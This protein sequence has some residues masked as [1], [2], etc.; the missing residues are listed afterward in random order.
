[1]IYHSYATI[2]GIRPNGLGF[3]EVVLQPALGSLT[4]VQ[5]TLPHPR[6]EIAVDFT[7]P[8]PGV[9]RGTIS[10]PVGVEGKL[11]LGDAAYLLHE[12]IQEIPQRI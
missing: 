9:L 1:P 3:R 8:K 6:G 2:L 4:A 7:Q 5:A 12:G 11:I 10:L